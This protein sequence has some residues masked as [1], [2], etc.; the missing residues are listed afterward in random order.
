MAAQQ[1]SGRP[2]SIEITTVRVRPVL[3]HE[4][5]RS[6]P[7]PRGST[8]REL[9]SSQLSWLLGASDSA[10]GQRGTMAAVTA[11]IERG[12]AS[13][14]SDFDHHTDAQL[15]GRWGRKPGEPPREGD[16]ERRGRLAAQWGLVPHEHQRVLLAHYLVTNRQ[17]WEIT[18]FA[19][20]AA[21]LEGKF[22]ELTGAVSWLWC[23]RQAD[24]RV[25]ASA[26]ERLTLQ[27]VQATARLE[28]QRIDDQLV[29]ARLAAR[30]RPEDGEATARVCLLV[31]LAAVVLDGLGRVTARA[32]LLAQGGD[33]GA[34]L[35]A[36]VDGCAKWDAERL[37]K[38]RGNAEARVR[39]AHR[40]WH[41]AGVEIEARELE[42]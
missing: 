23:R 40:A 36:L 29:V 25:K 33:Q 20:A 28:L 1:T 13:G 21:N 38:V 2:Q 10:L 5:Q 34:D 37:A 16:V 14:S 41:H 15:G 42:A 12:G 9:W 30:E 27:R 32:S 39:A 8:D 18:G 26:G 35:Q 11:A 17:L 3:E 24:R 6:E 7:K 4:P 19:N 31:A 22:G